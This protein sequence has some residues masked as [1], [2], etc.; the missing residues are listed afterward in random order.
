[1]QNIVSEPLDVLKI[2]EEQQKAEESFEAFFNTINNMAIENERAE[3]EEI[4][5]N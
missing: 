4:M 5:L 1:M 2:E 3:N